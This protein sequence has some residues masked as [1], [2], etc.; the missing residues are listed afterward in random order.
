LYLTEALSS[1]YFILMTQIGDFMLVGVLRN[2][3]RPI[4]R[5]SS[6]SPDTSKS[7]T[8][9][10]GK[11]SKPSESVPSAKKNETSNASSSQA[12]QGRRRKPK[13]VTPLTPPKIT[14]TA[15]A[16]KPSGPVT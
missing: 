9:W 11:P 1:A 4:L 6:K 2:V 8:E 3:L 10:N 14:P 16:E 13:P 12:S 15:D 5:L 7:D